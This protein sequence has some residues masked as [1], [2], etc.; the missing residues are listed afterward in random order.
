MAM[1]Y[2]SGVVWFWLPGSTA[3]VT[4]SASDGNVTIVQTGLP[5]REKYR[6]VPLEV[7]RE[8]SGD[9]VESFR[10]EGE[11]GETDLAYYSWSPSTGVWSRFSPGRCAGGWPIGTGNAGLVYG[12]GPAMTKICSFSRQ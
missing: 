4:I 7:T 3:L 8:P 9:I 10:E 11:H 1:G 6:E 5:K 12:S 2:A